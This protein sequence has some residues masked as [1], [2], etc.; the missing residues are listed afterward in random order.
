PPVKAFAPIKKIELKL[1]GKKETK[2]E[3]K[4]GPSDPVFALEEDDDDKPQRSIE[5]LDYTEE[6]L[7]A[8]QIDAQ[9]ARS[10]ARINSRTG[11]TRSIID[12]LPK[13]PK[14]LFLFPIDWKAVDNGKV[15]IEKMS[16]WIKKKIVEYLGEEEDS[17][18]EFLL[19]QLKAHSPAPA[20]VKDL[21]PV[22]EE[23]AEK[24]VVAMWRKLLYESLL[25]E[26]RGK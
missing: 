25:A 23:D 13:E 24:F 6:E 22:L 11:D 21:V 26:V 19:K 2:S 5:L 7:R 18:L 8:A 9:V 14:R 12:T 1:G 4:G 3:V 10:V 20:I 15:V 16:P 17:L